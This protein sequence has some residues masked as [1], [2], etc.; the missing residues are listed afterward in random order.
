MSI[1]LAEIVA[2]VDISVYQKKIIKEL[3]EKGKY[4]MTITS[5]RLKFNAKIIRKL[6]KKLY[7]KSGKLN[8]KL[9]E[10]KQA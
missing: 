1:S 9:Y 6:N 3:R 4:R 5:Q 7:G 10:K 8:K 2:L